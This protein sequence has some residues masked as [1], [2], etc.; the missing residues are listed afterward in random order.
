ME[1]IVYRV[2]MLEIDVF[3]ESCNLL[4]VCYWVEFLDGGDVDW[5]CMIFVEYCFN[6]YLLLGVG[7]VIGFD[8]GL[9]CDNLLMVLMIV[10]FDL[11]WV[12]EDKYLF[13]MVIELN[14]W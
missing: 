4:V 9:L 7:K 5:G 11:N 8:F 13:Y 6:C 12:I 1:E 10:I 3:V 14:G 2:V